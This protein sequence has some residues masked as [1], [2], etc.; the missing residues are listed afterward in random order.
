MMLVST[1]GSSNHAKSRRVKRVVG[2]IAI[3]LIV[4]FTVLAILRILSSVEW[5]LAEIIVA[6]IA[7]MIFRTVDKRS[8]Q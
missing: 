4:V 1:S 3:A 2:L 6:L 8:K 7:N 5:I